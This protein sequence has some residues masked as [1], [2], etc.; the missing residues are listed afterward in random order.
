MMDTQLLC[1]SYDCEIG[2]GLFRFVPFEELKTSTDQVL[3]ADW[4]ER[5]I[6]KLSAIYTE[7]RGHP[8]LLFCVY[9]II[10]DKCKVVTFQPLGHSVQHHA[11]SQATI[12]MLQNTAYK[13]MNFDIEING[14][15]TGTSN[16]D[17]HMEVT[18][19]SVKLLKE[20]KEMDI[21]KVDNTSY[22]FIK[23][24]DLKS[25]TI[26]NILDLYNSYQKIYQYNNV[27]NYIYFDSETHRMLVMHKDE[28][29]RLPDTAAY[30]IIYHR[31][32]NITSL[33]TM[34][35][36]RIKIQNEKF[37]L[38][39]SLLSS[40]QFYMSDTDPFKKGFILQ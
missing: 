17:K 32:N 2:G 20:T 9:T 26:Q 34:T 25:M 5:H 29:V 33:L 22:G 36:Q 10:G 35:K 18:V 31:H 1:T 27:D 40:S 16:K 23:T 38:E 21:Y 11:I 15:Y 37:I 39:G 6:S 4:K 13:G 14:L 28:I 24:I 8:Y 19:S 3:N 12:F 30:S 7:P